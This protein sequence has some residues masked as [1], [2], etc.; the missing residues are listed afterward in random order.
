MLVLY[1]YIFYH[2]MRPRLDIDEFFRFFNLKKK[3]LSGG[4]KNFYLYEGKKKYYGV[5][6]KFSTHTAQ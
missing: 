5:E 3:K 1:T 6:E 4:D 2:N